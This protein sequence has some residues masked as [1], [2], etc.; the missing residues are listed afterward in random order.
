MCN[1]TSTHRDVLCY[2]CTGQY[3]KNQRVFYLPTDVDIR[4]LLKQQLNNCSMSFITA[5]VE[6]SDAI[7]YNVMYQHT[8]S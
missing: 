4:M 6:S 8:L 1:A 2:S 3:D 5:N 7:L